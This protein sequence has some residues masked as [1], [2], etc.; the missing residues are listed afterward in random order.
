MPKQQHTVQL[1]G[2]TK[3]DLPASSHNASEVRSFQSSD[4]KFIVKAN[5]DSTVTLYTAKGSYV[6][7]KHIAANRYQTIANNIRIHFCPKKIVA[8][9]IYWA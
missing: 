3:A 9:L 2:F 8:T 1:I 6:M 7:T 4:K 5:A